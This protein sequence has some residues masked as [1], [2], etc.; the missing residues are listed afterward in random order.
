MWES[1]KLR[2]EINR[3]SA[4]SNFQIPKFP[5]SQISDVGPSLRAVDDDGGARDPAGL[6]RGEEGDDGGDFLGTAEAAEGQLALDHVGDR[7]GIGLLAL[8]PRAAG[9]HDRPRGDAVDG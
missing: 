8:V 9:K 4:S 3:L 6:G 1:G 5:H 7:R 2:A